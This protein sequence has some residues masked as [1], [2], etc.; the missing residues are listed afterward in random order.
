MLLNAP[1]SR[2]SES[3][4]KIVED[5]GRVQRL[6]LHIIDARSVGTLANL[7]QEV[8]QVIARGSQ[9]DTAVRE[10]AHITAN[11]MASRRVG[12]V[13]TKADALDSPRDEPVNPLN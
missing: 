2:E 11:G 9:L 6:R 7:G 4:L 1:R 12:D 3:N 5:E 10:V 13:V 8:I